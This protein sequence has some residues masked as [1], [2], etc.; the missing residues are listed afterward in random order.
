MNKCNIELHTWHLYNF[1][2]KYHP[3]KFSKK[4]LIIVKLVDTLSKLSTWFTFEL[5]LIYFVKL[6]T[7]SLISVLLKYF[8]KI[9]Q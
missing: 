9:K 1:I 7:F 2:N 5:R 6:G 3:N 8:E 4:I